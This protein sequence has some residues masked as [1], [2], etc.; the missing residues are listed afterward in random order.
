MIV[1]CLPQE[2]QTPLNPK[3]A[4]FLM[5]K[6]IT[7]TSDTFKA[8]AGEKRIQILKELGQRRKTQSEL[9]HSLGLSAPTV[10]EHLSLL[11]KAGLVHGLDEGRKW[12]YFALTEKGK[13]ILNPG[14][15]RILVLLGASFIGLLGAIGLVFYRYG[16]FGGNLFNR[17]ME[18]GGQEVLNTVSPSASE[19]VIAQTNQQTIQQGIMTAI[20]QVVNQASQ[21]ATKSMPAGAANAP[22][23]QGIQDVN[24]QVIQQVSKRAAQEILPNL[25]TNVPPA[26]VAGATNTVPLLSFPELTIVVLLVLV[27][28]VILGY[29]WHRRKAGSP[30]KQHT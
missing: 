6:Q 4:N 16:L 5:E 21:E 11:E 14:E 28:G 25:V 30:T 20:Q 15:S 18:T 27:F 10:A 12:K 26:P 13:E 29:Y 9:A 22:L 2:K 1:S 8:L 3:N 17:A 19:A 23:V 7:L 24:Q